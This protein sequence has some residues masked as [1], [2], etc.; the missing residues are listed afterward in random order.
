MNHLECRSSFW[1]YVSKLTD[2][3]MFLSHDKIG[4]LLH[5]QNFNAQDL[6]HSMQGKVCLVTGGNSGIGKAAAKA[7]AA[8]GAEVHILCRD[9]ERGLVAVDE[10]REQSKN[11]HIHLGLV[12]VSDL[13]SIRKFIK[14]FN[15]DHVDI[16]IHNAG[17]FSLSR[18]TTRQGVE[19][20]FATSVLGPH[21]LTMSLLSKLRKSADARV[22]FVSSGGAYTQKLNLERLVGNSKSYNG[23]LAYAQN[24][25]AQIVLAEIL[26]EKFSSYDI[27]VHAMHPGWVDTRFVYGSMPRLRWLS[28][29]WLRT[30][31]QGADT[32]VWLAV[33]PDLKKS[34]GNYWFDR[35]KKPTHLLN[36]TKESAKERQ[37][38][39]QLCNEYC[40]DWLGKKSRLMLTA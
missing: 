15:K 26:A 30:P 35:A 19:L 23:L 8:R 29:R 11:H 13:E 38:L 37:A 4:F 21:L 28:K 40:D 20:T 32:I 12:D 6:D 1:S 18:K 33:N 39:L 16:L 36:R 24:K 14:S 5:E 25:R 31:E 9:K 22:I 34:S 3:T 7:L 2:K 17:N 10:L 27:G